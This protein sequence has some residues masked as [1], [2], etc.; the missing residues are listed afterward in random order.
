MS[1]LEETIELLGRL[2]E[3]DQRRVR[4]YAEQLLGQEREVLPSRKYRHIALQETIRDDAL[5]TMY[6]ELRIG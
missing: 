2:S 6:A 5:D 3:K 4:D 1:T